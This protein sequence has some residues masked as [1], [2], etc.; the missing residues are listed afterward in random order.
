[1]VLC[2]RIRTVQLGLKRTS[3]GKN[4]RSHSKM[5]MNI[6]QMTSKKILQTAA[7]FMNSVNMV[8]THLPNPLQAQ[9]QRVPVIWHGDKNS[10]EGK[11]MLSCDQHGPVQFMV[12]DISIDPHAGEVATGRLFSGSLERGQELAVSGMP[13]KNRI[14]QVGIFMA[15]SGSKLSEFQP[16]TSR[17]S[18]DCETR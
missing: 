3:N 12:T 17:P 15:Q 1:M 7:R 16:V 8:I 5:Y 14:Q 13:N 6:V 2:V 4:G 9:K 18:P 11:A 10:D